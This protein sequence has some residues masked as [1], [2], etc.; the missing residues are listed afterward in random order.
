MKKIY[1][2]FVAAYLFFL[3]LTMP[4]SAAVSYPQPTDNFFVNDFANV[5]DPSAEA[6]MQTQGEKLYYACKAQVVV[7][8][9]ES[10]QGSDIESYSIGLARE[11]GIGDQDKDNGV[12][13]L[14]SVQD[15][16]VRVEVGYGLEGALP[17]SKTGRI[18]DTYGTD[19]FSANDFSTGLQA[20]Y[21]SL[22]NEVYIEY[23]LE[24]DADY[25][26]VEDEDSAGVFTVVFV[27]VVILL[28]LI[29]G[30]NRRGPRFVGPTFWG[31]PPRGGGGFSGG[32]G[33]GFSGGGGGFGGGG[34][35]RGF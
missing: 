30:R 28:I 3:L 17:D 18:L 8:T 20:V 13:L 10:L 9:V 32:G 7:V 29:F 4:A 31:G 27:I 2:V 6:A 25:E 35:S 26:P 24:P 33:G 5:V 15:R 21:D 12:L 23:G 14:L 34:S 22:V 16:K 1:A 11:W 19:S